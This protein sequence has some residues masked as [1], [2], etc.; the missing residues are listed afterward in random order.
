M[1]IN[2]NWSITALKISIRNK[3]KID[4]HSIITKHVIKVHAYPIPGP[5]NLLFSYADFLSY[6]DTVY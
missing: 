6:K 4:Q 3:K 5:H 2:D 1:N